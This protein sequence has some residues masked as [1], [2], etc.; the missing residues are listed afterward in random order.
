MTAPLRD[1]RDMD[2]AVHSW[3]REDDEPTADR[4]RQIGRIMGRVDETQ[5]QRRSWL[6]NPFALRRSQSTGGAETDGARR[7][8]A[9]VAMT[10]VAVVALLATGLLFTTLRPPDSAPLPAVVS[11]TAPSPSPT[12]LPV[13]P[14]DE[15]L[16]ARM[17]NLWGSDVPLTSE[18]MDLYAPDA[19]H[20]A[21]WTD[22]VQRFTDSSAIA[23]RIMVSENLSGGELGDRVR[24]EDGP[25]GEHRYLQVVETLAMP[26][27][28]W[29]DEGKVTRHD[30]I[31]PMPSATSQMFTPGPPPDDVSREELA[32]TMTRAWDG[33][34]QALSQVASPEIVHY[35]V[36]DDHAVRHTG[37]DEYSDVLSPDNGMPPPSALTPA[38][39]LPAP[40]GGLRW[41][42]Y[43]DVAGG[44]L[45]TFW[46][47]DDKVIRHDC[48]VPASVWNNPPPE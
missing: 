18:V 1:D 12:P 45:C 39:D 23:N 19:I 47:Q 11:T 31:L 21:L 14:A 48:I 4:S 42:D 2:T 7:G 8:L 26:C 16:F 33:D 3:L 29:L 34:A 32:A 20:T 46:A 43:N 37:I 28:W 30:C 22:R 13:D 40:E 10:A 27:V 36:F 38:I 15:A 5:Q 24:V 25:H 6:S 17:E 35:V 41:A 44:T 9:P